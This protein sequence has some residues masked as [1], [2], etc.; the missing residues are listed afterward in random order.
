MPRTR[1][2][3][4]RR[5]SVARRYPAGRR[6]GRKTSHP[7]DS[8]GARPQRRDLAQPGEKHDEIDA[9]Q[10]ERR[11]ETTEENVR[12]SGAYAA[13]SEGGAP[14]E[15]DPP[16]SLKAFF[17]R[18]EIG[19]RVEPFLRFVEAQKACFPVS[20]LCKIKMVGVSKS[21]AST[22]YYYAWKARAP[23]HRVLG[24]ERMCR[25]HRERIC[26][27]HRRSRQT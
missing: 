7:Q 15:R 24:A 13:R 6:F 25:P 17:A 8:H 9:G 19:G 18:E 10:R 11:T 4:T 3:R 1:P 16:K 26:E 12:S 14:G 5:S 20:L 2:H 21:G 22:T 27:V 23:S